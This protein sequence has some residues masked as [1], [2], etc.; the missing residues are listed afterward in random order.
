MSAPVDVLAVMDAFIAQ[1]AW[2]CCG[3]SVGGYVGSDE[4]PSCCAQPYGPDTLRNVRAAVAELIAANHAEY[5]AQAAYDRAATGTAR[6]EAW[7]A[8]TAAR[9]RRVMALSRIGGAA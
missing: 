6:N 8:L 7:A 4:P 5:A 2:A 1:G 9:N 3:D